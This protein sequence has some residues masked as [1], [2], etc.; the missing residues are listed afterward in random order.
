MK[1]DKQ[2]TVKAARKAIRK[3]TKLSLIAKLKDV[4]AGFGQSSKNLEKE[5]E[6]AAVKFSKKLLKKTKI[7]LS[8]NSE[9][10]GKQKKA[11]EQVKIVSGA[12]QNSHRFEKQKSGAK[13]K[14]RVKQEA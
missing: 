12:K 4:L 11:P 5:I 7:D 3:E 14:K 10:D 1:K 13:A 6:K 8:I 9:V 2:E